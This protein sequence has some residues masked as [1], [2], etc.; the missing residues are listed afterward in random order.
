MKKSIIYLGIA[1]VAF[2]NITSALNRQQSFNTEYFSL[3]QA[4]QSD[5]STDAATIGMDSIEKETGKAKADVTGINPETIVSKP[6]TKT[7]EEIIAENNQ[8]IE[9]VLLDELAVQT[10][11]T[12]IT[13]EDQIILSIISAEGGPVYTTKSTEEIILE[14]SRII[15]SPVTNAIPLCAIKKSNKS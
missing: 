10:D 6:Y 7:M 14:D 4:I 9:S 12:V 3:T 1:V 15:E 11:E 5:E 2:T 13:A 8:I